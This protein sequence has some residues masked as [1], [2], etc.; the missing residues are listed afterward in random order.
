MHFSCINARRHMNIAH[1]NMIHYGSTGK[2]MLQIAETSRRHGHKA[3]TCSTFP[4]DKYDKTP[5]YKGE[6][7]YMYGSF[8]ENMFHYY[9]GSMTGMNGTG[10]YYGTLELIK[11]LRAFRPDI[12]HL[13]NLH[14]F[15]INIPVLFNYLK[16]N[17]IR[18][19]W[20][21]HDCWAFTGHCPYFTMV[22]CEKWKI[23][24]NH[25]PQPKVYPKMYMDSSKIMY[26]LKKKW[27]TGIQDM[28]IVTPS[29][30]L[31]D[32]VGE[33]FLNHY[34]IRVINNGIDIEKFKPIPSNFRE[35]Y[36]IHSNEFIILGVSFGWGE[37]K[38]L[39]VFQRLSQ[40][41][42]TNYRIV[43]VGTDKYIDELLPDNVISI[44]MTQSQ[45]E[46]AQ[47]YSSADLFVNPTRED[48]YPTVNMESIACGTPVLTFNTGGSPEIIDETCGMVVE[49]DDVDS[50]EKQIR[51]ICEKHPYSVEACLRKAKQFDKNDKFAKYVEL[52]EKHQ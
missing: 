5:E 16:N 20:T 6:F 23:R 28:T 51:L 42:P 48:N 40:R 10:S 17:H 7:H 46:L 39:D 33:S 49:C 32:L 12:V 38:G 24:C 4:Y 31:A 41:L 36:G 3:I 25:C 8:R 1:I 52:Y 9:W 13:H 50:L 35:R 21:L 19:I 43:L 37:R 18:V 22:K 47:V 2:I 11:R 26:S 15:C 44:H 34:P 14:K 30:W 45:Q 27:F 29:Q